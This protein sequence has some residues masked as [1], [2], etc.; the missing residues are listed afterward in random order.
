MEPEGSLKMEIGSS[1]FNK[2]LGEVL[3]KIDLSSFNKS[4]S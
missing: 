3:T 4:D 2:W 1:L